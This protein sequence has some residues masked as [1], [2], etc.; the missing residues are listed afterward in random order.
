MSLKGKT[1]ICLA[2][3]LIL[4]LSISLFPVGAKAQE[5][6]E[7]VG[8]EVSTAPEVRPGDVLLDDIVITAP[9]EAEPGPSLPGTA[10]VEEAG[11]PQTPGAA[12]PATAS[13]GPARAESS[14]G[15]RPLLTGDVNPENTPTFFSVIERDRFEGK[16]ESLA[17]V[18][19][20]EA[21]VQIRQAGGLG[22]YAEVSIRGSSSEQVMVFMDGVLLNDA[23]GGGVDLSNISL[24]DVE[25]IEIYR[26]VTPVNFG[27]A[28][29]G[30]VVNIKTRR[31]QKGF[32]A[33]V[34]AGYGS[35]GTHKAFS[36]VNHKPGRWDYLVSLDWLDSD[37]DFEMRNKMGTDY[38]E[39]DDRWEDR[40]NA[41]FRQYNLLAKT[42]F[43]FS[44]DTR[45]D[46]SNQLFS[47]EQGLPNWINR[48]DADTSLETTRNISTANLTRDNLTSLGLNT[49][50]RFSYSWKEETYDDRHGDVGLGRQHSRYTTTRPGGGL[51]VEWPTDHHI[52]SFNGEYYREEYEPE[53]LLAE[54]QPL[55]SDRDY[56]SLALQDSLLFFGSKLIVTPALRYTWLND[57]L[58]SGSSTYGYTYEERERQEDYVNPQMGIKL[59]PL[60]WL[61]LKANVAQYVREPSFFELFGDRG[62]FLGNEDLK[63]ESGL[64]YDV[65]FETNF[66]PRS[67]PFSR[68]SWRTVYF[69]SEVDDLITRVYDS[70]GVGRSENISQAY[71]QG[72][73][74]GVNVD[75]LEYFT[76]TANATWQ[77]PQ[78]RSQIDAFDGKTLP[79]R[80]RRS[81]L[82]RL[83]AKHRGVKVYG[84]YVIEDG[85]YYDSANLLEAET[86]K[87]ANAGLSVLYRSFLFSLE[88]Q[89]LTDEEYEDYHRF[90]LPGRSFCFTVQKNF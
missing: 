61:T 79:G 11:G 9:P 24:D 8:P 17:E 86:K 64:N 59:K 82:G 35:F 55:S 2:T 52:L 89:N 32:K 81:Y 69:V 15:T 36:F 4:L 45:L 54:E 26:G 83:E 76:L 30:G 39:D 75:F 67:G 28:S 14:E 25:A 53:N 73:E 72:V 51:F 6:L 70:R 68:L 60:K 44:N 58:R 48:S 38:N 5:Q 47:K 74:T 42:G 43:D 27:K 21:G 63:A 23:A 85:R 7:A 71:I 57:H 41:W 84:E 22:S 33:G 20:K 1:E 62:F 66:F 78:N 10:P 65:G 87:E 34:G 80:F 18:I 37:N 90:P 19:S 46:L 88:G 50:L 49:A 16:M 12:G 40:Q 13:G 29:I 3:A 77:D 31:R 56:V